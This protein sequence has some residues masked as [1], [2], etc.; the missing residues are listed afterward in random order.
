MVDALNEGGPAPAADGRRRGAAPAIGLGAAVA[1]SDLVLPR[2]GDGPHRPGVRLAAVAATARHRRAGVARRRVG[3]DAPAHVETMVSRLDLDEPWDAD[4]EIAPRAVDQVPALRFEPVADALKRTD[5]P[6]AP[7]LFGEFEPSAVVHI[8]TL[9][10]FRV[11]ATTGLAP[12]CRP[13][14]DAAAP[15]T[16]RRSRCTVDFAMQLGDTGRFPPDVPIPGDG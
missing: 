6:V 13:R 7:E 12:A 9:A 5:C 15:P 3:T 8:L 14:V 4:D 11:R 10:R 2:P 16:H 1:E